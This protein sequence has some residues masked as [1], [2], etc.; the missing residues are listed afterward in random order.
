M[1]RNGLHR[2]ATGLLFALVTAPAGAQ[3]QANPAALGSATDDSSSCSSCYPE[4]SGARSVA[5]FMIGSSTYAIV[6]AKSDGGVQ[7]IDVST[8][9][10]LVPKGSAT[11]GG[12]DSATP[13]STF[14]TLNDPFGVATFVIGA[15]TYAI[16]ASQGDSAVQVIDVSTPSSLLAISSAIDADS[17]L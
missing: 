12:S 6:A 8:P 14:G 4:L 16:V 13:P 1:P 7:V 2:T 15:S 11:D 9:Y 10:N 3:L 5:T 17:E